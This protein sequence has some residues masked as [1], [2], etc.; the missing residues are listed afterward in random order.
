VVETATITAMA[1][2]TTRA[3]IKMV[4]WVAWVEWA[5]VRE[6]VVARQE[7]AVVAKTFDQATQTDTL[8]RRI[9]NELTV[10]ISAIKMK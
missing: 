7:W 6:I 3:A 1:M 2:V 5:E 9:E 8:V 4:A 10:K